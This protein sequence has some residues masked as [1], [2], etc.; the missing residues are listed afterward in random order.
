MQTKDRCGMPNFS[1][2]SI[3]K[4]TNALWRA[5]QE[6]NYNDVVSLVVGGEDPSVKGGGTE[7]S[8][9]H[10]ACLMGHV[11]IVRYLLRFHK[12]TF[13]ERN[14][15]EQGIVTGVR[16]IA[17]R[18]T[19]AEGRPT[20]ILDDTDKDG[21]TPIFYAC[22]GLRPRVVEILIAYGADI[23]SAVKLYTPIDIAA[24]GCTYTTEND[25]IW[26]RDDD[27]QARN[28]DGQLE[29][30]RILLE[31]GVVLQQKKLGTM[32]TTVWLSALE[33]RK[34]TKLL[35]LLLRERPN[36][37]VPS[38]KNGTTMM[39]AVANL[40]YHL[41]ED[42]RDVRMAQILTAHGLNPLAE[43]NR[44]ETPLLWAVREHKVE[45]FRYLFVFLVESQGYS[46]EILEDYLDY[47]D[48]GMWVEMCNILDDYKTMRRMCNEAF[49][50]GQHRRLGKHSFIK[51]LDPEVVQ[52]ILDEST[53]R[54]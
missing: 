42:G 15:R 1:V 40:S 49:V 43:N 6:G 31:Q 54:R 32:H 19:S 17:G 28:E 7:C 35:E 37:E 25:Y 48:D 27:Y 4:N 23:S 50:M 2:G 53:R 51:N 18:T 38:Y 36:V 39:H 11:E 44:K 41:S 22:G 29:V 24:M 14:A 33:A 34:G 26:H 5:A 10:I 21:Y 9:L 47:A 52:I 13:H 8:P 30:V 46:D 20:V 12:V 45:L 3:T 16:R